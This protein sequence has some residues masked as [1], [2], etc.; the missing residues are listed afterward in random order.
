MK[1]GKV[2]QV[3]SVDFSMPA[4]PPQTHQFLKQLSPTPQPK[5]MLGCT[6]WSMKEW[7]G[8]V[9]PKGTKTKDY[10][11]VYSRQFQTIELNTTHYRIPSEALIQKWLEQSPPDFEFCPKIP[12][13]FSHRNDLGIHHDLF[14]EFW[15]RMAQLGDKLGACFMQLPPYFNLDRLPILQAFLEKRP[16]EIPLCIEVRHADFFQPNATSDTYFECLEKHQVG[17]VIT[18]VAGRRDVLHLRLTSPTAM[19]RFVGN[20]LHPTDYTRINDWAKL[21]KDWVSQGVEKVFFFPHEPDNILAPELAQYAAGI[22]SK[23]LNL[24]VTYPILDGTFGQQKEEPPQ[25]SLFS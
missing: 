23:H 8:K 3:D 16:K 22:F 13:I 11:S 20:A 15:V 17:T 5:V 4:V 2:N 6:G 18:D 24:E 14:N 10:L 9:Y 25:L 1:F 21:L 7:V 12:Q 19:I